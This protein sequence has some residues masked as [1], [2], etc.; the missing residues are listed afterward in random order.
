[1]YSDM[2]VQSAISVSC[3]GNSLSF[4][5][6]TDRLAFVNFSSPGLYI[7]LHKEIRI[8]PK[9]LP[10]SLSGLEGMNR[11]IYF[12]IQTEKD[13]FTK[14]P[15]VLQTGFIILVYIFK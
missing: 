7:F 13:Y 11:I 1:M 3:I 5:V 15:P 9:F 8:C 12:N 6:L 2:D 10:K 4:T 14:F